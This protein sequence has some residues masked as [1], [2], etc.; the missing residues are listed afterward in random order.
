LNNRA[1]AYKHVA[2][3]GTGATAMQKVNPNASVQL[4]VTGDWALPVREA[5]PSP[6]KTKAVFLRMVVQL[7]SKHLTSR[8]VPR[9]CW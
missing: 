3:I 8:A 6:Q 1:Q 2:V 9:I 4:I 5:D 7:N